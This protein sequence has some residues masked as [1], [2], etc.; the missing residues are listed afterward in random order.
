MAKQFCQG[1]AIR[2]PSPD[3]GDHTSHDFLPGRAIDPAVHLIIA[4]NQLGNGLSS[5][6]SQTPAPLKGVDFPAI[7]IRDDVDA[8]HRRVTPLLNRTIREFLESLRGPVR[9]R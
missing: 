2:L 7:A 4:K 6:P 5:S 1:I 3:S 9:G 8:T